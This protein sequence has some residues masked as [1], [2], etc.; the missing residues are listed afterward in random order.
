MKLR[1]AGSLRT[2]GVSVR[3]LFKPIE[4][5]TRRPAKRRR[6]AE[7]EEDAP[8]APATGLYAIDQLKY[9]SRQRRVDM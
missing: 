8:S 7:A 4:E 3:L 6:R 5:T 9:L 2:D 1:F